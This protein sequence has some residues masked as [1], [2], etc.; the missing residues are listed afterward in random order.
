MQ[1]FQSFFCVFL[2]YAHCH[3]VF[4]FCIDNPLFYVYFIISH[5]N[6]KFI[7]LLN[8]PKYVFQESIWFAPSK[9]Y[10]RVMTRQLKYTSIPSAHVKEY[11]N[12]LLQHFIQQLITL[13]ITDKLIRFLF[14]S[15]NTDH[16]GPGR[17]N[18]IIMPLVWTFFH[19]N[20]RL[21][22]VK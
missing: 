6:L 14:V 16:F 2:V 22:Q 15:T 3:W 1:D 20:F 18:Q 7:K 13:I 10:Q 17:F 12:I 11:L 9:Y 4:F 8:I 21:G 5:V 19:A